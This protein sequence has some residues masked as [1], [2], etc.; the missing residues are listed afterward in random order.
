M[1]L[2][3]IV[4][5]LFCSYDYW[6]CNAISQVESVALLLLYYVTISHVYYTLIIVIIFVLRKL[7]SNL[8]G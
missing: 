7:G 8:L 1:F 2:G 3:Y 6:Q 5:Q 4:F